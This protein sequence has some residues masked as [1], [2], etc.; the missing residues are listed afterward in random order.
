MTRI[1]R[2]APA[3]LALAA[4]VAVSGC[5]GDDDTPKKESQDPK[6]SAAVDPSRVSPE[7]L[8]EA[9]ELRKAK[10][11]VA[12]ASFGECATTAGRQEVAGTVTNGGKKAADYVVTV[13]W[14]NDTSDVLARGVGVVKD[15]A[16]GAEREVTLSAK[17][18]EGISTCTFHVLRGNLS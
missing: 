15:L 9:P 1:T 13:S 2:L 4:L 18:P 12:D 17:V 10:G 11:A 5:S 6:A 8:P 3:A 7:D 14:I 16:P